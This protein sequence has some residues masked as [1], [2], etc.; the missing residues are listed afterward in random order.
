MVTIYDRSWY[1]RVLVE[2]LEGFATE[3]EWR[4]TVALPWFHWTSSGL[5]AYSG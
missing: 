4:R 5:A 1:G 3:P 2:R